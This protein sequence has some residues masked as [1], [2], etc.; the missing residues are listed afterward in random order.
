MHSYVNAAIARVSCG[1]SAVAAPD[2]L[3]RPGFAHGLF[4]WMGDAG[5][6]SYCKRCHRHE[7]EGNDHQCH[8]SARRVN[9]GCEPGLVGHGNR[10]S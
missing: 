1:L 7:R 10:V 2:A 3:G 9:I 5:D 6:L 8:P 4:V